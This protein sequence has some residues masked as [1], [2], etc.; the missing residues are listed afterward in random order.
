MRPWGV[1]IVLSLLVICLH[2]CGGGDQSGR[3]EAQTEAQKQR[4]KLREQVSGTW[5]RRIRTADSLWEGIRIDADGRFGLLGVHTMHGLYWMVRADT[6]VLTTSTDR[7]P[8]PIE[9]RLAVRFP[10]D[11]SLVLQ[12]GAQYLEG[13]YERAGEMGWRITGA[14]N[15]Q[16]NLSLGTESSIYLELRSL[17]GEEDEEYLASQAMAVDRIRPP[18]QYHLYYAASDAE[19]QD[20]ARL[21]ATLVIEGVPTLSLDTGVVVRL[22]EDVEGLELWLAEPET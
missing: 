15:L 22:G 2:G 9:M 12:G 8:Q 21:F 1:R 20:E 19:G 7:Y 6:L 3:T 10:A 14:V 16:A 11:D 18:I 17:T 13:A 5:A 4:E